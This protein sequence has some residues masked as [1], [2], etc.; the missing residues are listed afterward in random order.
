MSVIARILTVFTLCTIIIRPVTGQPANVSGQVLVAETGA[1]LAGA[2]LFLQPAKR[3]VETGPDGR[4]RLLGLDTGRVTLTLFAEGFATQEQ[5][6][7]LRSGW[8]EL[9]LTM[10]ALEVT[11]EAVEVNAAADLAYGLHRLRNVD[12]TAIYAAKKSEV[13]ELDHSLANLATNNAR[14]I[15]KGIPGLN[16]WENDG[17]GLQLAIGAR[18]LDPNR[19]SNFN[20]RQNGYDI[21]AD[22]LGY[23]ESYYT[24]PAQA[25]RRIEIVRGAASLQ[26]GTQFGGLLNFVFRQ[27]PPDRPFAFVSENTV[28]SFGLL[29]SFNSL[30]GT[31]GKVNYYGFYQYKQSDGWRPNASL[32]QH[33]AFANLT[34]QVS[35]DLKVGVEFTHMNYLAQQPG[36]LMDFEFEEDP[37]QSKRSRNWFE[38]GWNLGALTLDYRLSDRTRLNSRTFMLLAGRNA[39]GELGPISRPDPMRERDL[40]M[41]TYHNLGNET[42]LI[43]RYSL[44]KSM[45]NFLIGLRYYQ[46]RSTSRQGDASPG[47]GPDF[48]FLNSEEPEKSNYLFPSRNLAFFVENLFQVTPKLTITP[49]VRLE[50]IRTASEGYFKRRVFAGDQLIFE[51]KI[52][53]ARI[54]K[55]TFALFGLGIGYQLGTAVE[56]YSNISQNYR[57]INFSDLAVVNPNLIVDSLLQDERG[58]NA[59]LGLRGSLGQGRVRFDASVFYLGYK[60][61]IGTT[62]IIVPDPA[63]GERAVNYRTNVGDAGI[64]GLEAYAEA[65]IWSLIRGNE[66]ELSLRWFTNLSLLRGVYLSG[67]PQVK[68]N[69]VELIP[70]FS[71]KTGL[72]AAWRSWDISYQYA[73]VAQ[74]FSDA[75]NAD[76][77]VDATRGIIPAYGV[78][79]LSGRYSVGRFAF[80]AGVNNLANSSYFTRRATGYP[81]PGIIPAAPRSYYFTFRI[82]L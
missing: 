72:N 32:H 23:P 26:Y 50:Y 40:I 9:D 18:G 57:A 62:E 74:H 36:G 77:V 19:T 70:P 76:F 17:A 31:I 61:R 41:G 24:P 48:E 52:E 16:I 39:L 81:G 59:D 13:I 79:D 3:L 65:D 29:N 2:T 25:L 67:A 73:Y 75:T 6:F 42:R 14:E 56:V 60:G 11:G 37:S 66:P 55:R 8:Q 15:Y 28:G 10:Q 58:F 80:Q 44:G 43:H 45:A 22:A 82:S 64:L 38:V 69:S 53:D 20:T 54:Q 46:G 68:G 51:E 1:N 12:G 30:G 47:S 4:F 49:G 5:H 21:S 63:V 27:G 34:Y 35:D 71:L 33:T 7:T 78:M